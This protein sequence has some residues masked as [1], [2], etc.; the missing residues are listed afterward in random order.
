MESLPSDSNVLNSLNAAIDEHCPQEDTAATSQ[1]S[2]SGT[3]ALSNA[4]DYDV[5]VP[6]ATLIIKVVS[7]DYEGLDTGAGLVVSGCSA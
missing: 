4:S 6:S 2:M 7:C 3:G 1:S 5:L